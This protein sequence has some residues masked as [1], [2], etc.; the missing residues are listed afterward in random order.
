[1]YYFDKNYFSR[2]T[3]ENSKLYYVAKLGPSIIDSFFTT[4]KDLKGL[5]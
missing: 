5:F 3:L 1:M 2:I 4:Y